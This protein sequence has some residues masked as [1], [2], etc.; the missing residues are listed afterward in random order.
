M[1]LEL[2]NHEVKLHALYNSVDFGFQVRHIGWCL[3]L[4]GYLFKQIVCNHVMYGKICTDI[5]FVLRSII[6]VDSRDRMQRI[7]I[8]CWVCYNVIQQW[9][10]CLGFAE[11]ALRIC[12]GHD[13]DCYIVHTIGLF[14]C[15]HSNKR[16]EWLNFD[17]RYQ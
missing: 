6:Y 8:S 16:I 9:L 11:S 1:Y 12:T 2:F 10:T 4:Y 15:E 14:I 5:G 7:I 13:T 17:I 3:S